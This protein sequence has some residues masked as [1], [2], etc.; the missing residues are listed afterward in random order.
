MIP[1]PTRRDSDPH[2]SLRV[3]FPGGGAG[4]SRRT[5]LPARDWRGIPRCLVPRSL[6][7]TGISGML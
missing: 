4:A 5:H 1:G 7:G 3:V 6:P 2:H